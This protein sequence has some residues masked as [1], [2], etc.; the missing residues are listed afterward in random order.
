[1]P[2]GYKYL[3]P[4]NSLDQGEPTNPSD[5]AA[6][7]HDEAYAAYLRSGKNPYLYFSPADQRFI[8]QTKD[9]KDWGG[10]IG[11]Y[12]FRAKKA[13]APVLTDTPDHPS[14]SRPTKP[15]KRSKPPPH[16]F[17]NLAKKKKAGAGQV[18]R[19]NLAPMSD[20]AVQPDGGQPAV[21]NERAT[22]SGNGSGGGGGGG[23]G[24][25]GISTGTFNNQTEF[26]FLENGWV[27]ITANSSR[28]VHLNMP[29]SENY[30]RV[31]VN[32]LDKTAVNGNMALD[33]THAQIVT[34]WSL[35]D[36]NAWGVWFNPGDWQLIVNTMSELHLVSFEQEIFNVVLKTVSESA[37][38]PPTK[39]YNNDLTASLMVALDSNNTMP[40]TPAAMRS[41]TLGFYPWKPTIPTP[42]RYYFQWD[43]TLIPSHTG[44]SGTPTNIYHGTDPDD[45][46]FYTIENSVPVHLLR[47]GDE[48]ATGTF[49]FDCKPCRLTHTWQT[50][51]ALGLPPF[52][53]SLPQAEGGTNFGYIGVQQ[54]KRRGVTQM[55]N[56]NYIT[57]ATIMRPAE[58]GYS[59]PYYSFEASTQGPFKT[60]IAAGRGGAQTD[61]NQAADGDPRYA[62]GRQHGQKTTTT[63]ET[64][65]RFTYIAHQDTGRY[66]EGD[67]IQ[68]I[69]FNLPVTEDNVLLPTDPIGGKAGINYTNI[70]NTYG[71][72]TAL[73][74]VPPVYPNGQIWDKEFDTD[75]KPRLHVNAPF[76]CQNNC[77]GQL[78]VKVAPNLTN[79]YDPDASANMSRIV[80]YSDFW[81]KGKLVFKAKLRASHTWNPIQQMSI[82][83]D[84]QFNYVPSNIGGMKIVYEKSQLAPRKLY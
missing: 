67:W 23:S 14:T 64:P 9:A 46:Q 48:F 5:A 3:G 25:V 77:P 41:E 35:V 63:G 4:G 82:N 55:G 52:L 81:W 53:N 38:Q 72:L 71:P 19:D 22:G 33:D 66:P 8:D 1:M 37:T 68:N 40:F 78:F 16:I 18:K 62:F 44:T 61:E 83:V 69:N 27:E 84:N 42:W 45:V 2:P 6:K 21:R 49:F 7:E 74:N 79:E 60:P 12:F 29:E 50:N 39:V 32:N 11:H 57:E 56:T 31:V 34:P 76:V 20:G 43:R 24:G 15:T 65:E 47:T 80:T 26:K 30:R 17:I 13:I 10:K 58:V 54:D 36:A 75:L 28:L 70:F 59:A 73:N 51:R